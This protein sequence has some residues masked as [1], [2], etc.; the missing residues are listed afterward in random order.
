MLNSQ[1]FGSLGSLCSGTF[2]KEFFSGLIKC[3]SATP[4]LMSGASPDT[5]WPY[6]FAGIKSWHL[7][8]VSLSQWFST[9]LVL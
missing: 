3:P 9:F 2:Y 1:H 5:I 8:E 7:A 6:E 4:V